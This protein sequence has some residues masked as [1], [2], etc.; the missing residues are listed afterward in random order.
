MNVAIGLDGMAPQAAQAGVLDNALSAASFLLPDWIGTSAW[1][2]HGPF[3][4]WV[5]EACRPRILVELGTHHGYSYLAFCQAVQ[6]LGLDTRCFA[7]DLWRGDEHSG[8]YDDTVLDDLRGYH[9]PRF[10]NFSTLVRSTFN[11]AQ[12]HFLDSSIDLLHIDGMHHYDDV[13]TDFETWLPKLSDRAVVL[14]HDTNVRE[15]GFG[16]FRLWAE[17]RGQ[18]PHFEFIHGHGLGVLGVGTRL[19]E[20]V[21]ELFAATDEHALTVRE[22]Y[23]RLGSSIT[24][25]RDLIDRTKALRLATEQVA[26]VNHEAETLRQ[27]LTAHSAEAEALRQSL[28]AHLAEAESLRHSLAAHSA[29]AETL[30]QSLAAQSAEAA[31][32]AATL[33]TQLRSSA[34]E[35]SNSRLRASGSTTGSCAS[36]QKTSRHS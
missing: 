10:A 4:F 14:F 20:P 6:R 7:I 2:E 28:A 5:V 18:Y 32:T 36:A 13:K 3:A 24:D 34:N 33:E 17:L 25:R 19:P 26:S 23:A 22:C 31:V 11:D 35:L 8:F 30:R 29:E 27:S 21:L 15:R 1:L 16:V 12:P 9:D